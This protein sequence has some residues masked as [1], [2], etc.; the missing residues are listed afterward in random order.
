MYNVQSS[1]AGSSV[2][3]LNK[4]RSV[5]NKSAVLLDYL[6]DCKADLYVITET[7]LTEEDAAV[8]AEAG[9]V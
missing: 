5:R 2:P 6:C 3:V 9:R 8:R 4:P 1:R 7:W